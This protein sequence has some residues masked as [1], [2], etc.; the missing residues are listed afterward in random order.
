MTKNLL[1]YIGGAVIGILL[2]I[3]VVYLLNFLVQKMSVIS[4]AN[5]LK[6]PEIATF[7]LEKFGEIRKAK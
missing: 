4:G 1:F 5:L 7:N 6:T 2:L 3:Y